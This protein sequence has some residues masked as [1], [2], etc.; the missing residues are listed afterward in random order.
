MTLEQ[1][2]D[3]ALKLDLESRARLAERLLVS[4]EELSSEEHDRLWAEEALRRDAEL[5]EDPN[6]ELDGEEVFSR[7]RA[8]LK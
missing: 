6:S 2:E 3:E 4:L 5:D 7:L 1:L 8:K